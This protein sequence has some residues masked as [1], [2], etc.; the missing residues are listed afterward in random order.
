MEY[1]RTMYLLSLLHSATE[2]AKKE[3]IGE[4]FRQAV[5]STNEYQ[6]LKKLLQSVSFLG[7]D[8]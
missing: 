6:R 7:I 1:K 5:T 2:E 4:L 3:R 8:E